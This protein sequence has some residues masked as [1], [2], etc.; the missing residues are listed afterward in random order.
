V[1]F[2]QVFVLLLESRVSGG[3]DGG[4]HPRRLQLT[5]ELKLSRLQLLSPGSR[6]FEFLQPR[7]S[8]SSLF[9]EK[10]ELPLGFDEAILNQLETG[11]VFLSCGLLGSALASE[12]LEAPLPLVPRG[13]IPNDLARLVL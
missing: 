12:S 9:C 1:P 7:L 2:F 4:I 10:V 6:R 11:R 5:A 3:G 8:V 13:G